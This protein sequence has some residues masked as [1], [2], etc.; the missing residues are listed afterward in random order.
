MKT[1]VPEQVSQVVCS[2]IC[3]PSHI[4]LTMSSS[5][6][7]NFESYLTPSTSLAAHTDNVTDDDDSD[8]KNSQS[9]KERR[10]EAHTAAEQKR[11]DAIKKGYDSLQELVPH[12]NQTDQS[13]HKVSKAVVLQ[14]SIEFIQHLANQKKKQESE[15]SSLRKE[16]G[17]VRGVC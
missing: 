16:V 17:G 7:S 14:K 5:N 2:N 13:G 3:P 8:S 11:R 6:S 15:L 12:C 1:S 9:Y 4:K 10:R